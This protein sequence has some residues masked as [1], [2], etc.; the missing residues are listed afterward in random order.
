MTSSDELARTNGDAPDGSGEPVVPRVHL[1]DYLIVLA[2]YRW[3]L[4]L[5]VAGGGLLAA[6]YFTVA[7]QSFTAGATLLPPDKSQGMSLAA[8][9]Q[10]GSMF[11]IGALSENSSAETFVRIL[12]SHTLADSL[13]ERL[14]LITKLQLDTASRALAIEEVLGGFSVSADRQGFVDIQYTVKTGFVPDRREQRRAAELAADVVNNAVEVLD[15]LNQQKSV[16]RARRSREFIGRMKDIKRGELDSVQQEFLRFQQQNKA[17]ALDKQIEAS[18]D[19]LVDLQTQIQKK[20]LELTMMQQEFNAD[21]RQ[22]E[23]VRSQLAQLRSQKARLEGGHIGGEALAIPMSGVPE[24]TRQYANLKLGMEV[25][26]EIYTY[27][28]AQYNQ[29]Q[30]Q[31]ARELPTVSVMDYATPPARRSAPKRT[32]M[33][34]VTVAAL[35]VAALLSVFIIDAYRRSWRGLDQTKRV[36]LRQILGLKPKRTANTEI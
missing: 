1:Y 11:D 31:E 14:D 8:L 20:E 34:L 24:L 7:R 12:Q 35:A 6:I 15:R 18:V 30:I 17:I 19:A 26:T 5:V 21:A 32:V 27:L 9:M 2:R 28:E 16:T 25:A 22:V 4:I 29:E 13:I 33:V 3:F 36:R 23:I 10:S